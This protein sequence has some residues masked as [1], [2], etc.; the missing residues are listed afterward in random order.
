MAA[1]LQQVLERAELNKLP[2]AVQFKLEKFFSDHQAEIDALKSSHERYK[3]DSEQQYFN[4]EKKLSEIQEQFVTKSR[5]HEAFKEENSRLQEELKNL[6]GEELELKDGSAPSQPTTVTKAKYELEAEVRELSR[7]L[8]KKTQMVAHLSDNVTQ[9][10]EKLTETSKMKTELQLKLDELQSSEISIQYREKRMEQEKELLQNQNT[11]LNSELKSKTE[12]LLS[13]SREKGK[14]LLELKCDLE[15]KKEEVT[16]LQEQVNTL[17]NT[18]EDLQKQT[19]TLMSKLKEAKDQY[20]AMEEKYSNELSANVK[21]TNLYKVAAADTEA[22]NVELSRAVEEISTLLKQSGEATKSAEARLLEAEEAKTKLEEEMN[23]KV[24]TLEKAMESATAQLSDSKK[25]GAPMMTEEEL[26][27]LSPTAAAVAKIVKPGMKLME[28]YNAFVEAQDQ[29]QLEKLE[30]KR[31]HKLLDEIVLEVETKAPILRR[32]R[33]EYESMQKSTSSLCA[34]LEQAMKEIRSLQ[35]ETNEANKRVS[36]LEKEKQWCESQGADLSH[37]V[38]V[39][40]LEIEEARGKQVLREEEISSS[41][42]P[43]NEGEVEDGSQHI[44]FRNVEELQLQNQSLLAE[45]HQIK[46][47]TT[48]QLNEAAA[49]RQAELE[50]AL[51]EAQ[52]ELQQ[53]RDQA[54]QQKLLAE[55]MGRQRDM[56]RVLLFQTSDISLPTPAPD[57]DS[58]S[59][60]TI[61]R[62][63]TTSRSIPLRALAS[64][65]AQAAQTKAALKQL[66]EAFSTYKKEKAGND[67]LL[68]DQNDRLQ[69]RVYELIS[70]KAKLSSQLEFAS[71][72]NDMIQ[73]NVNAY[74]REIACLC[75]RTQKMSSNSQR[76]EQIIHT[77]TQDLRAANEKLVVAEVRNETMSKER[78]LLKMAE[79]RLVQEK[80]A[81]LSEQR[82]QNL[83]LAN[84]KTMQLSM[85]RVDAESSQRKSSQVERLERELVQVKRRL[86]QEVEQRHAISRNQDTQ[87]VEV[88]RQLETQTSL[89]QKT[90]EL[91]RTAEQQVTLL[92]QQ[93]SSKENSTTGARTQG[94]EICPADME[95]LRSLLKQAEEE[96]DELK[97]RLQAATTSVEQYRALVL[98]LEESL[99]KEKQ[100]TEKAHLSMETTSKEMQEFNTEL[101]K[102]LV[103]AEKDKQQIEE[104]KQRALQTLEQQVTELKRSLTSMQTELQDALHRAAEAVTEEQKA[105]QDRKLQAV[106]AAEAQN[107]YERELMLHAADVEALREAKRQSQQNAHNCTQLD[108]RAQKAAMELNQSR[109]VWEQQEKQL[110]E[111]LLKQAKRLEELQTQNSLLHQQMENLG[112]QMAASVQ[113]GVQS[114]LNMSF[115]EEDK[116]TKEIL[117]ILRFVRR[118]KE[119]AQAQCEVA[120]VEAQRCKQRLEFQEK[121]LKEL[122][123]SINTERQKLQVTAKTMAQHDEMVK[124]LEG[125]NALIET[126]KILKEEKGRLEQ[127]LQQTQAKVTKMEADITPLQKSNDELSEK[128]GMLQAE[129]KLME[130]DL[131]KWKARVQQ[132]VSQQK[133]TDQEESKKLRS[134]R[135]AHLKRIQHLTEEVGKMKSEAARTQT[136]YTTAQSQ[137]QSLQDSL[138]KATAERDNIKKDLEAKVLDIQEKAKTITQVKKIGRRYKTQYEELK[139]QHDKLVSE[140]ATK[141]SQELEVQLQSQIQSLNNSLSQAETKNTELQTQLENLQKAESERQAEVQN[142]QEQMSRLRQELQEKAVGEEKLRQQV[143]EMTEKT[144]K[145]IMGAKQKINQLTSER[146]QIRKENDELKQQREEQDVRMSALKSQYEARLCRHEREM[147]ELRG[148]SRDEPQDQ[149]GKASEQ[150]RTP[151]TRQISLKTTPPCDRGST[152]T[153]EPPTANIKP[154]PVAGAP[155]K[156]SPIPTSKSTPRASIRPMVTPASVATP[157][158]TVMPTTQVDTQE[159]LPSEAAVEHVSVLGS[160]SG[161]VRSSSPGLSQPILTQQQQSQATAFVQPTQQQTAQEHTATTVEAGVSTQMERPSTSSAVGPCSMGPKRVREEEQDASSETTETQDDSSEHPIPKK[162]RITQRIDTEENAG[163]E[164]IADTEVD[165]HTGNQE[166]PDTNQEAS[167]TLVREGAEDCQTL[168]VPFAQTSESQSSPEPQAQDIIVLDTG[169]ESNDEDEQEQEYEEEQEDEGDE[170]E[171]A[172]IPGDGEESNGASGSGDTNDAYEAE[173]TEGAEATDPGTENEESQGATASSQK[174]ADSDSNEAQSVGEGHSST[175]ETVSCVEAL[176]STTTL[177]LPPSPRR[178]A[179]SLPPRLYIQPPVP[180]LGP[181]PAQRQASQNRRQSVGRAPQLTPGIPQQHFFDEDDRMV[182]STPTLMVQRHT[183]GFAEA[184]H[185][186]QVAGVPRF[187]F[188]H[189]D[190]IAQAS[191]SH[192]D[193]GQ[194]ASQ[195]GLGMY[196]SPLFLAPHEDESGGRSVPTTPLQVAAPVSVFAESHSSDVPESASQSVPMVTTSTASAPL[197]GEDSDDVFMVGESEETS[198]D[199]SMESHSSEMESAPSS[200]QA[201]LPSTSQEPT[202]SSTDPS[203]TTSQSQ[204]RISRM[205]FHTRTQRRI[206]R[207]V[208]G[209]FSRGN[210]H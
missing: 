6:K 153:T 170:D 48:N 162:I 113:E 1:S 123:E 50:Q 71:K 144:K 172:E 124:K 203:S 184:I 179:H 28:L 116:S 101:E 145:A 208:R 59:A 31:M 10:S 138:S 186:P 181:P 125:M 60:P 148:E 21:L 47:N 169:S 16:R 210:L 88:R 9:L 166:A 64:E 174:P 139:E 108:E 61:P 110:K 176:P 134:E 180:E 82:G 70:Q 195:G 15:N 150:Q 53:L 45:L 32:Q 121:E 66:N 133:D 177:R 58:S 205:P 27:I 142:Q 79:T 7:L 25:R 200:D 38:R 197:P 20:T 19:E 13:V 40:L 22:K 130:E 209:A 149:P 36:L 3:A 69:A 156:P 141:Q 159:A 2:K 55:S 14:D 161:S 188:G 43:E 157:T 173:D 190:M 67:K 34:K 77:M 103:E 104:E 199:V 91:L 129:M 202:S 154:T 118:D 147:R 107:K 81:I 76:L 115:I 109:V 164:E 11:W 94:P 194:L 160:T 35:K 122:Q 85:E 78:D 97:E 24:E 80:E 42:P 30:N 106:L 102:K 165:A 4:L 137:V 189:E 17:R 57:A 8:E 187:R 92:R 112:T 146:E 86:E 37:Q 117:E 90:K 151:D 204:V 136:S 111:E 175:V 132:L 62:P 158:A 120:K 183:D 119:I 73:N 51:E 49:S 84:L 33:E 163:S 56:Y 72:R 128:S 196:E 193:L 191:S 44:T 83:L 54:K 126:N 131:K 155:S 93:L 52:K 39:L 12:E 143:S 171:E 63:L 23:E 96:R 98:N 185:S 135:E 74:R 140:M 168:S 65:S 26:N 206:P 75:E 207:S 87:V 41:Q 198:G 46:E 167:E 105:K 99:S 182:P 152:S 201:N 5:E 127:N 192:S 114:S 95:D 100:V 178:L 29:L 68:N 89:H 18:N